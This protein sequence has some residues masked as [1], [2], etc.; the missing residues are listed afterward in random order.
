LHVQLR[1]PK[2]HSNGSRDRG[3]GSSVGQ[4]EFGKAAARIR[5]LWDLFRTCAPK[6]SNGM[7]APTLNVI[8]VPK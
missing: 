7:D 8:D 6:E 3:A 1:N 4:V 2:V 5:P